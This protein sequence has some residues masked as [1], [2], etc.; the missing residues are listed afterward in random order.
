MFR[1]RSWALFSTLK[2]FGVQPE[3]LPKLPIIDF[4]VREYVEGEDQMDKKELYSMM[5]SLAA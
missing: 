1:V 5:G 2:R 3:G 4:P